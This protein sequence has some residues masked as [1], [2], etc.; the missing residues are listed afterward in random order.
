MKHQ[1]MDFLNQ[2]IDL[3]GNEFI[4]CK[5]NNCELIFHGTTPS[6]AEGCSFP[7]CTFT[8]V[9]SAAYTL[10][11]LSNLYAGGF[12]KLVEKIFENIRNNLPQGGLPMAFA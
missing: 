9:G 8:F 2:I 3:D 10:A 4:E 7:N 1:K 5:F 6:V 11:M 12:T